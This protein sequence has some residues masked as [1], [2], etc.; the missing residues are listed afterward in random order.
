MAPKKKVGRPQGKLVVGIGPKVEDTAD[1]APDANGLNAETWMRHKANIDKVSMCKS[2]A[3]GFI[4]DAYF[5]I[6]APLKARF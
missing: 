3:R 1:S 6:A 4:V 5:T 2:M